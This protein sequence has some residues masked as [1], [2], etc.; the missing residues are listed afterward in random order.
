MAKNQPTN[1]EVAKQEFHFP[2]S[3]V[4]VYAADVV[5][6]EQ[7]ARETLNKSNAQDEHQ[8]AQAE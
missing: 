6:A 5:E 4:T 2:E 3:G 8:E 7:L 1:D